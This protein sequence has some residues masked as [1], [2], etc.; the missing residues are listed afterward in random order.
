ME[1]VRVII[2]EEP[3]D[4]RTRK[5]KLFDELYD[6]FYDLLYDELDDKVNSFTQHF[7]IYDKFVLKKDMIYYVLK[8]FSREE[9]VEYISKYI[10]PEYPKSL[11][12]EDETTINPENESNPIKETYIA[13]DSNLREKQLELAKKYN[14][15]NYEQIKKYGLETIESPAKSICPNCKKEND[16]L[17]KFCIFC[18][19]KTEKIYICPNCKKE[20]YS[21]DKF[22][23]HC[24]TKINKKDVEI[25]LEKQR[26][27]ECENLLKKTYKKMI[28]GT[29]IQIPY[30]KME[31]KTRTELK[32]FR[33]PAHTVTEHHG[34]YSYSTHYPSYT[35]T[36]EVEI[37][38][39]EKIPSHKNY[40]AYFDQEKMVLSGKRNS[41]EIFY[42]DVILLEYPKID[43]NEEVTL[44]LKN[45]EKI[46]LKL[47][48]GQVA[49]KKD[50]KIVFEAFKRTFVEQG[51]NL[52]N[53]YF[54]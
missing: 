13:K 3:I 10:D 21:T 50:R 9:I 54:N 43:G 47:Y 32:T 14:T 30:E 23:C 29:I 37:K 8:N 35:Y 1:M 4:K 24:G 27:I 12:K 17:D 48:S 7:N 46:H 39:R 33:E 45:D 36:K 42:D 15:N 19:S 22:C 26:T 49:S 31:I 40:S 28:E 16:F 5:E 44:I 51:K 2:Q 18:G 41:K 11:N 52:P 34:S 38:E 6:E 25:F 53:E 20:V